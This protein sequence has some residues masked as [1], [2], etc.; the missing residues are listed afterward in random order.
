[1]DIDGPSEVSLKGSNDW[2]Q[3]ISIIKKFATNQ[4]IW[5]YLDPD[6]GNKPALSCLEEP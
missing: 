3:W 6:E 5:T 2:K 1:M 4:G